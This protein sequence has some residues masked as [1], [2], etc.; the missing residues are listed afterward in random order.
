MRVSELSIIKKM[1]ELHRY[2]GTLAA[3]DAVI[4]ATDFT[5]GRLS[6][7]YMKVK[8]LRG[9][10]D[11][12][13][14]RLCPYVAF[15]VG[16]GEDYLEEKSTSK[17][18]EGHDVTFENDVVSFDL[19]CPSR[20]VVGGDV[21]MTI[22]IH[23]NNNVDDSLIGESS[24]SLAS[25]LASNGNEI[26]VKD[27]E[28]IK[29]GDVTTNTKTNLKLVFQEAKVGM[30]KMH[31]KLSATEFSRVFISLENEQ[32]KTA[33]ASTSDPDNGLNFWIDPTNWFGF[34]SVQIFRG[35]DV[36]AEGKLRLLDCIQGSEQEKTSSIVTMPSSDLEIE[37]CFFEA[38]FV[39][40]SNIRAFDF[41]GD[42]AELTDPR[43]KIK[44]KGK[45][46]INMNMTGEAECKGGDPKWIDKLALP[47]VDEYIISV[48]FC[49][50]DEV[51]RDSDCIGTG[52]VNILPLYKDGKIDARVDLKQQTVVSVLQKISTPLCTQI[53]PESN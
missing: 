51:T 26:E 33:L 9:R 41:E 2:V 14:R 5:P 52:E 38:G 34:F 45:C 13:N 8:N 44:S 1:N 47:V 35:D 43:I 6:I 50:Y 39:E 16:H 21:K 4:D 42:A 31:P 22:A 48:D 3:D 18:C 29:P 46:H 20:Y 10:V 15:R 40:I 12:V 28:V 53:Q 25:I 11:E 7:T 30:I 27:I 19:P 37:H 49:E 17:K 36:M 23:D 24:I 32:S